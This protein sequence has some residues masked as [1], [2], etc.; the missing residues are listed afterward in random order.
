MVLYVNRMNNPDPGANAVRAWARL[1]RAQQQT[2]TKVADALKRARLPQLGWYDVLLELERTGEAGLRPYD[3]EK[4][5]LLPQYGVSRLLARIEAA[6]HIARRPCD[7]DGR[8]HV[9]I[10]TESGRALRRRM[11]PVYA[12]ALREAVEQR[13]SDA[14]AERLADLLAKLTD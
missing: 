1:Q 12:S 13:L 2:M 10:I 6:G 14:E 11:W 3:L 5:L 7:D 9:L 4:H 8:G